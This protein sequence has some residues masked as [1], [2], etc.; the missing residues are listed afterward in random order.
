MKITVI[1]PKSYCAGVTNAINIALKAK[2][3]YPKEKSIY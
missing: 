3:D 2:E 1:E